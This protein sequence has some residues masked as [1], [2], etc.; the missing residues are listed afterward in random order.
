MAT[1]SSTGQVTIPEPIREA[2]G[3][4]PGSEVIFEYRGGGEAVIHGAGRT[5]APN[6]SRMRGILKSGQSTDEIMAIL[7]GDD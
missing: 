3:L 5:G 2:L 6:L 4:A 1:I 7:R